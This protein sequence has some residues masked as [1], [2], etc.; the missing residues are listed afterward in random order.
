MYCHLGEAELLAGHTAEAAAA[1]RQALTLQPRHQPSC[2]LLQRI[3]LAQQPQG[4][5]RK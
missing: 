3:A 1:A 5:L 2:D 4:T